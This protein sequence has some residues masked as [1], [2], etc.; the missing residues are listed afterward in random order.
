MSHTERLRMA[1]ETEI[2]SM[3]EVSKSQTAEEYRSKPQ[4]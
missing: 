4:P 2:Y 1:I 3:N